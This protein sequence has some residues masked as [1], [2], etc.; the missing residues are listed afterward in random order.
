M[1]A[2]F[3]NRPKLYANLFPKDGE[4]ENSYEDAPLDQFTDIQD[5]VKLINSVFPANESEV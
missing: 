5:V 4:E 3:P 2:G 1:L